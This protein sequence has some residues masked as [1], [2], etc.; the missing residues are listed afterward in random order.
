MIPKSLL[1]GFAVLAFGCGTRTPS[2]M[3]D[4]ER[5]AVAEAVEQRVSGYVEAIERQD[6]EYLLGFWADTEGFVLAGDGS[7]TIGYDTWATQIR[8][9][10][11]GTASV[12]HAEYKNPH[13]YVL[14]RD[15]ASYSMEFDWSM[16]TTAG[17]TV[18]ATGAWTYVFKRLDGEWKVV[19]SAG[20]HLYR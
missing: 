2:S 9:I 19:Q 5:A 11:A 14:A 1:L 16:A 13:I 17:D 20:T 12:L 18:S 3:T 7:L 6:L 10:V 8:E 4:Q 15:A